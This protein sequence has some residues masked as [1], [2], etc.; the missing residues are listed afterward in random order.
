MWRE[1]NRDRWSPRRRSRSPRRDRRHSRSNSPPYPSS[2]RLVT[3]P[4]SLEERERQRKGIPPPKEKHV[5]GWC[6]LYGH[7]FPMTSSHVSSTVC[8]TTIW[9]GHLAKTV[10]QAQITA[11]FEDFGQVKSVDVR[12]D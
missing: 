5:T 1:R 10:K 12:A 8:S 3:P 4:L 6:G 7:V 9:I 2:R 11:A